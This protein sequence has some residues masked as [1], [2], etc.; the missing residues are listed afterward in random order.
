MRG[1]VS[2]S[3]AGAGPSAAAILVRVL[4]K[5]VVP[6]V[7]EDLVRL[8]GRWLLLRA[9]LFFDVQGRADLGVPSVSGSCVL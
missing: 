2:T 1:S 4:S 9:S 6:L 8:D 7:S 3:S 5:V